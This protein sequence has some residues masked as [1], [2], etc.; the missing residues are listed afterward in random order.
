MFKTT[1]SAKCSRDM[2]TYRRS[3]RPPPEAQFSLNARLELGIAVP[4]RDRAAVAASLV[5]NSTKQYPALLY[6]HTV[7]TDLFSHPRG[8]PPRVLV[9]NNLDIDGLVRAGT[10]HAL[11][12]VLVHPWLKLAHPNQAMLTMP[13]SKAEIS[14]GYL[15]ESIL[16]LLVG[17]RA[18][19]LDVATR[20]GSGGSRRET[21]FCLDKPRSVSRNPRLTVPR[22]S[23]RS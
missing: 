22:K 8:N 19:R 5:G 2:E 21:H 16:R 13:S 18:E 17:G 20:G 4:L 1:R 15:P 10:E 7:S 3:T 9:A 14:L 11:D 23:T 12:E 6:S